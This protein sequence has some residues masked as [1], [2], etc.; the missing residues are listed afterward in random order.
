MKLLLEALKN[1][2]LLIN[3]THGSNLLAI[4]GRLGEFRLNTLD[5]INLH[6]LSK[7][8]ALIGK[9]YLGQF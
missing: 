6:Q 2:D 5:Q 7:E 9:A 4:N 8:S 3:S 1:D